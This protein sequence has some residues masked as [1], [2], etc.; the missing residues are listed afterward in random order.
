[1]GI[2]HGFSS[3]C[4][5]IIS[6]FSIAERYNQGHIEENKEKRGLILRLLLFI[7]LLSFSNFLPQ[8]AVG[9][10]LKT[11][12][13]AKYYK[14]VEM[15]EIRASNVEMLTLEIASE[16]KQRFFVPVQRVQL[17]D[18]NGN[19]VA[20][21]PARLTTIPFCFSKDMCW[22]FM[23]KTVYP[24]PAIFKFNSNPYSWVRIDDPPIEYSRGGVETNWYA[25]EGFTEIINPFLGL[26][27]VALLFLKFSWY[28]AIVIFLSIILCLQI[29]KFH[30]APKHHKQW[31]NF[32]LSMMMSIAHCPLPFFDPY[33]ITA[34]LIM[35][36]A[37]VGTASFGIPLVLT[38]AAIIPTFF[39]CCVRLGAQRQSA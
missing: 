38:V 24:L 8:F 16:Q 33:M 26:L 22:V 18:E 21:T 37:A 6:V 17:R 10:G 5:W 3:T 1:M 4:L 34:I 7:T 30:D 28:F 19:I 39:L 2:L 36:V 29:L 32:I 25:G 31:V 13:V 35:F 9:E 27:G 12:K 15:K 23:W 20:F 11:Q 14:T